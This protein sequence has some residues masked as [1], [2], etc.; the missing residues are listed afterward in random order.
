MEHLQEAR[1]DLEALSA[2]CAVAKART[3]AVLDLLALWRDIEACANATGGKA[4]SVALSFGQ[5]LL[6]RWTG[7]GAGGDEKES[8]DGGKED[9][10]IMKD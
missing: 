1:Q 9:T 6:S 5:R 2:L 8:E 10:Y 3:D 4:G 7:C